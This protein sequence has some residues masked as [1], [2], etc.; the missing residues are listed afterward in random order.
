[1][2]LLFQTS[3]PKSMNME[4]FCWK[5]NVLPFKI[6]NDVI[7]L[8]KLKILMIVSVAFFVIHPVKTF[9]NCSFALKMVL[10]K[11]PLHI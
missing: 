10:V 9:N 5:K 11:A 8:M 3:Y 4:P 7:L 1:M 2:D 6:A